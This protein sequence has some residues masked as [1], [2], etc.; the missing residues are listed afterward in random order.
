[1]T[2]LARRRRLSNDDRPKW[3]DIPEEPD[4]DD[5][6]TEAYDRLGMMMKIDALDRAWRDLINEHGY[7]AVV[8][9]WETSHDPKAAARMLKMRH[10]LRQRELANARYH[11]GKGRRS[12]A[13][14]YFREAVQA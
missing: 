7:T 6:D 8:H 3:Q 1:M 11:H 12:N 14:K 5:E 13:S 9:C 10:E 4:P 2:S